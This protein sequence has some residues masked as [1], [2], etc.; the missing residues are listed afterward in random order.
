MLR[1]LSLLMPPMALEARPSVCTSADQCERHRHWHR[2]LAA[3]GNQHHKN[4]NTAADHGQ[5]G[6][7]ARP[8]G[9][10]EDSISP[11]ASP[12]TKCTGK[13]SCPHSPA[14]APCVT[15]SIAPPTH[16]VRR[17]MQGPRRFGPTLN[18]LACSAT[19]WGCSSFLTSSKSYP[20]SPYELVG[21][22]T[23]WASADRL[24]HRA[25]A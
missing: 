18:Q 11:S 5:R 23:A 2:L 20:N 6:R 24:R 16:W 21:A 3:C 17:L 9:A 8:P 19:T 7:T 22:C 15:G 4:D 12:E 10:E 13:R 1:L 14:H 25:D